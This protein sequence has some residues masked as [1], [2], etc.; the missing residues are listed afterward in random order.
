MA[1]SVGCARSAMT[2]SSVVLPQPDGPMKE[3]NSPR[4]T[5]RSM[6]ESA[7]TGVSAAWKTSDS[8]R[9]SMTLSAGASPTT[10]RLTLAMPVRAPSGGVGPLD[11][12]AQQHVA[13]GGEVAH[14]GVLDLVVADA[15][16]A[17]HEDHGGR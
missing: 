13:A 9:M 11:H 17:G 12:G 5:D 4:L 16:L 15:V 8:L 2:R 10:F 1:P 3:T 7:K 6:S 14:R